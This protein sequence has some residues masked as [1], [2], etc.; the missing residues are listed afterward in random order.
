MNMKRA[1]VVVIGLLTLGLVGVAQEKPNLSGTWV[2]DK[3]KSDPPGMGMGGRG[4]FNPD[5]TLIIEH[6]EPVLKIKRIVK[7]ERGEQ[8][9]E[10]TYTTDGKENVNPG[11]RGGEFRSKTKWEKGKLV[12]KGTQTI[13]SPMGTMDLEVTET[14][15][16]SEDGKTLIIETTTVTPQGEWTRKQVF[17][18][19]G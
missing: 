3:E 1:A 17:V 18:K 9:Q 2:L 8:V 19:Q 10:L 4:G 12:T 16:L 14:R 11:M 7:T 15:R 13:Q 6:Q 5:I